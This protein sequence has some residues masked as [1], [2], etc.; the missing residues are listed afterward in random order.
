MVLRAFW[1]TVT[2]PK[3]KVM[4]SLLDSE[5]YFGLG[6]EQL[7]TKLDNLKNERMQLRKAGL[8]TAVSDVAFVGLAGH[9]R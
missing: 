7:Q 2:E 5:H 6:K 4:A 1:V 8:W 9:Q 3:A